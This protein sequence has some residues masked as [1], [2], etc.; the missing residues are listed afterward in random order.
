[1]SVQAASAAPPRAPPARMSLLRHAAA[2]PFIYLVLVPLALLDAAASLY[3]SVCFRLWGLPRARRQD[4]FR[5]DRHKL[6]Y[7][8]PLQ[9]LNCAYCGYANGVLAF[10]TEVAS[11][12]EQYWCPIQHETDPAAPHSRYGSFIAF[13][14]RHDLSARWRR[15]RDNL[16]EA[17]EDE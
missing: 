1:M 8:T 15:L 12:T 10:A 7:L 2:A 13:G 9:K 17:P 6:A 5:I 11:R 4:F 3:Q 16:A 14:D